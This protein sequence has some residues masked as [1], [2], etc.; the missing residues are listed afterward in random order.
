MKMNNLTAEWGSRI[1]LLSKWNYKRNVDRWMSVYLF[2]THSIGWFSS[3]RQFVDVNKSI[4]VENVRKFVQCKY[5]N[6]CHTKD[7]K[8]ING[9]EATRTHQRFTGRIERNFIEEYGGNNVRPA[10][11]EI[12]KGWYSRDDR[13]LFEHVAQEIGCAK[14]IRA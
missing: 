3:W 11:N 8:A 9:K 4:F 2:L 5:S 6:E 12:G 7:S 10:T 13:S 14:D 1:H